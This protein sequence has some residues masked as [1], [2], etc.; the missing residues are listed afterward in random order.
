MVG[1]PQGRG[2]KRLILFVASALLLFSLVLPSAAQQTFYSGKTLRVIVPYDVGGGTDTLARIVAPFLRQYLGDNAAVQ[3]VNQPGAGGINGANQFALR[4]SSNGTS[5]LWS[6]ASNVMPY[7]LRDPAVRYDFQDFTPIL[8][9]IVSRVVFASASTRLDSVQDL[10]NPPVSLEYGAISVTGSDLLPIIAFKLLGVNVRHV[11]GFDGSGATR[12]AFERG[13]TNL[14][15]DSAAA[16]QATVEP[17]VA[18]GEIIPLFSLGL[19]DENGDLV[20]DPTF[21]EMPTVAEVY[22]QLHG[23]PP[24]GIVWEAYKAALVAQVAAKVMWAHG[25]TPPAALDA[26]N[27]AVAKLVEDPAFREA[28]YQEIG[29]YPLYIGEGARNAFSAALD[30]PPEAID[31]IINMLREDFGITRL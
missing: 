11:V 6:S 27:A 31:W 29:D 23:Q 24:S 10:L 21:P 2:A 17:R 20:R 9:T 13:E 18:T 28:A 16:Y 3:V 30:A 12:L 15:M 14:N 26:L 8:G 7:L 19:L 4:G 1:L 25:D 5:V 22:E